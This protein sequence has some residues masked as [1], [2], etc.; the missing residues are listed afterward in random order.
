V[1]I[2]EE[3]I[4]GALPLVFAEKVQTAAFSELSDKGKGFL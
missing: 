1:S 2:I 3:K 4:S